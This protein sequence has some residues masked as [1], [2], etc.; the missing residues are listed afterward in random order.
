MLPKSAQEI[1]DIIGI[2]DAEKLIKNHGGSTFFIS[3]TMMIGFDLSDRASAALLAG[4]N[5]SYLYIPKCYKLLM[6]KRN[7]QIK[8]DRLAGHKI[9]E[10]C[11]K[12][13]LT[14]RRIFAI[15]AAVMVDHNQVDLFST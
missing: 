12:Y 9:P 6:D 15:C 1:I 2:A 14:D 4:F 5:G 8:A 7:S 11:R 3:D 10:L 13:N